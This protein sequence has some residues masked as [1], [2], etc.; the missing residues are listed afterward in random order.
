MKII[1][2]G[3]VGADIAA[4]RAAEEL[5]LATGGFAP[6]GFMT[7]KGPNPELETRYNLAQAGTAGDAAGYVLRSKMNVDAADVTIAIY[8]EESAGTG[9]TIEYARTGTWPREQPKRD[10]KDEMVAEVSESK[11]PLLVVYDY[12]TQ[13]LRVVAAIQNFIKKHNPKVINVCG[14]RTCD[15]GEVK[16]IFYLALRPF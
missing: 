13:P 7:I 4:L 5:F 16:D 3:Q 15:E 14:N 8:I 6:P 1:S 10:P 11:K 2:G 12:N 9:K